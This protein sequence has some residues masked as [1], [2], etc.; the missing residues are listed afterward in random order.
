MTKK[1]IYIYIVFS[2][3]LLV[4]LIQLILVDSSMLYEDVQHFW[5]SP[6][7]LF[8]EPIDFVNKSDIN[9]HDQY[10]EV[11]SNHLLYSL[12]S[13]S[14]NSEVSVAYLKAP[15]FSSIKMHNSA[16]FGNHQNERKFEK[17]E[18]RNIVLINNLTCSPLL[19]INA[20]QVKSKNIDEP[21][22]SSDGTGVFGDDSG[23]FSSVMY[24]AGQV[25]PDPEDPEGDPIPLTDEFL[26]LLV[27]N[28]FYFVRK[29]I[30]VIS[31][32][33]PKRNGMPT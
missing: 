26:I 30:T 1:S 8:A 9:S 12:S 6:R 5:G 21:T 24:R 18:N 23:D 20:T 31:G 28:I 15:A 7:I 33:M 22:F 29:V 17:P 13:H 19:S 4:A 14:Q 25:D 27:L 32:R 16:G 11:R 10:A 3:V 2:F